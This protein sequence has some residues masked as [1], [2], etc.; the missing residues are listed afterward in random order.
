ML[1]DG[2][3]K[4]AVKDRGDVQAGRQ[5]APSFTQG[6][7]TK[8]LRVAN[9]YDGYIDTSDV[10]E[11]PFSEE[12]KQRYLLR[13]GD[14]LLN[15]G[16][17]LELVGRPAI[18]VGKPQD[19][20]FQNTLIRFRPNPSVSPDFA[21]QRFR[22]CM[23][24]GTFQ[25]IASKTTSIAHL[26]VSRFAGLE[27]EWPPIEEQEEIVRILSVWN[28]AVAA[29]ERQLALAIRIKKGLSQSLFSDGHRIRNGSEKLRK[30]SA[31]NVF[32]PNSV[33]NAGG[34]PLLSV[35]QDMGVVPRSSLGRKVVMPEGSTEGYK[36]VDAGDFV[37]SLR[38]FE[39]GLEYSRHVGLVSPAYTVLKPK[40]KIVDDFY[41]H[42]FK[43]YDFIG[44]LAVAVIGIRDGKQISYEDFAFL[45]I[46]SPSLSEQRRIA[47]VLNHAETLIASHKKHLEFLRAEKQALMQELLTGKRRVKLPAV[48]KPRP[49]KA[50]LG[51]STQPPAVKDRRK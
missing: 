48:A 1:P 47:D 49:A 40:K 16:Q 23:Y 26:G 19:C 32:L 33:K 17:S 46:P 18:Y 20:C 43:S 21:L 31:E 2:W 24:D 38:S 15:E 44:R 39:G 51:K 27:L 3:K 41:R 11:M 42:Y 14:I 45:K 35:M 5:R 25:A 9:V 8:Y 7:S 10:M 12:E 37:I 29:A 36:R 34:L 28:D 4:E 22:L 30:I 50:K 6:K 13:E